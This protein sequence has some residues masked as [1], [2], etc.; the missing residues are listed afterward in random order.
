MS[1]AIIRRELMEAAMA[2][3]QDYLKTMRGA[4][5]CGTRASC[6]LPAPYTIQV[7]GNYLGEKFCFKITLRSPYD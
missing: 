6:T 2:G 1:Q 5:Y 4:N 3:I 7:M